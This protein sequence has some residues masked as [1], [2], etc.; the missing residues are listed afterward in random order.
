M[1]GTQAASGSSGTVSINGSTTTGTI[2]T[3]GGGAFNICNPPGASFGLSASFIQM[4]FYNADI[5]SS[6]AALTSNM[7]GNG[8]F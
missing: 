6:V 5:A 8:G 4:A 2:G 7:R 3:A 1:I